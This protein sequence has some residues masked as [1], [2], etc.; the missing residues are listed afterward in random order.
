M[1]KMTAAFL[2]DGTNKSISFMMIDHQYRILK[3]P[4]KYN[5]KVADLNAFKQKVEKVI[6][7]FYHEI[8]LL[9]KSHPHYNVNVEYKIVHIVAD[10]LGGFYQAGEQSEFVR[11]FFIK[12][13]ALTKSK[14]L[15]MK[16]CQQMRSR[17]KRPE[18]DAFKQSLKEIDLVKPSR[19]NTYQYHLWILATHATKSNYELILKRL[20]KV[21]RADIKAA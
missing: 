10:D 7:A 8:I 1:K 16:L 14:V 6:K 21:N 12:M 13:Y 2:W 20:L 18:L 17:L 9:A 15:S 5:L 3:N 19:K 11:Q 4:Q